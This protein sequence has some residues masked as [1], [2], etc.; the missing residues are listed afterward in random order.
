MIKRNS[1]PRSIW[2]NPIHFLA[3]GLGSGAAPYA[4]GTFGTLAAIPLYLV[5]AHFLT[6]PLYALFAVAMFGFGVWLCDRTERD[7]GVHDHSGIVWDE[8]VGYLVT[9]FAVPVDWVWVVAGFF[10]FRLFDVW[11][12]FPVRQLERRYQNG[13]GNMADDLL[14]GIYANIV[15]QLLVLAERQL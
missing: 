7:I 15:L 8:F 2:T 6:W 14:A 3:F 1:V 10:L 5:L 4:P 13:F 11:K 12:P 9:M